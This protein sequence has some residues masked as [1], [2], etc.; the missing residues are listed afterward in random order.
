MRRSKKKI[1][2]T[3]AT[4]FK[5]WSD[6]LAAGLFLGILNMGDVLCRQKLRGGV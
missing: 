5:D 1:A 6:D 3:T 2:L 4:E